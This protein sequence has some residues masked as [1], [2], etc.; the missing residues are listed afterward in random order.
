VLLL[1]IPYLAYVIFL[2]VNSIKTIVKDTNSSSNI[3]ILISEIVFTIIGPCIGFW[4]FDKYGSDIPF[5]KRHVLS[6]IL[7]VL[8]SSMSFWIAKLTHKNG[9]P[10]LRIL[11]SIGMLQGILLCIITSIHFIPFIPMGIIYPF[12][13]FELLS[14][15]IAL[16]FLL[17][18]FNF[19]NRVIFDLEE[20]LP[21]R[22]QLGFIPLPIKIMQLPALPRI[23]VYLSG[24]ATLLFLEI[25][26]ASFFGQD[27]DSIIK[28]FTHSVGFIF[29]KSY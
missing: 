1:G 27:Y 8:V 9:N 4:R 11:L 25:M 10:V 28:A 15:I 6:I 14:P 12:F 22:A 5:D 16:L 24:V 2:I 17:K 23:M 20:L 26:I 18:E 7:L 21:Y 13:G 29:S 19:Y 3:I